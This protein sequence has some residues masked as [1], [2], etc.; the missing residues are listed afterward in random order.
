M[1]IIM[2]YIYTYCDCEHEVNPHHHQ[3]LLSCS[4]PLTLVGSHFRFDLTTE[5]AVELSQ[6]IREISAVTNGKCLI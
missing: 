2:I 1:I 3:D 6:E 5:N 4:T